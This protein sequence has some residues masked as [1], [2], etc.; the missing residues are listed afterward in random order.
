MILRW[1]E[2]LV[3]TKEGLETKSFSNSFW[4]K[5]LEICSSIQQN[6]A[7]TPEKSLLQTIW[8]NKNIKIANKS[9]FFKQWHSCGIFYINDLIKDDGTF[10][11][12]QEFNEAYN[13][14]VNFLNHLRI[15]NAI[16]NEWRRTIEMFGH[17][18][19]CTLNTNVKTVKEINLN[20]RKNLIK[21]P[22]M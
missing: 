1:S 5:V 15:Q 22:H 9:V 2:S 18:I 17:N 20:L 14:N 16:P 3:L 19:I 12:L 4:Q 8:Y 6:P 13:L 7:T 10:L 11:S 21:S